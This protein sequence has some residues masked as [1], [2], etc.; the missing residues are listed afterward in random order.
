MILIFVISDDAVLYY[1]IV[2]RIMYRSISITEVQ[3]LFIGFDAWDEPNSIS[4]ES[5][6]EKYVD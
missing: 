5:T 2:Q 3:W 6:R 4:K 1:L